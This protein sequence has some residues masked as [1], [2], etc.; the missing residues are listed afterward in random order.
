MKR[1][2]L[3]RYKHK[4]AFHPHLPFFHFQSFFTKVSFVKYLCSL[5]EKYENVIAVELLN[6]P[7]LGG[8][9]NLCYALSIWRRVD[10]LPF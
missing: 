2:Y 6:E 7:P 3:K 9:P 10:P 8:L 5:W 4:G 1:T